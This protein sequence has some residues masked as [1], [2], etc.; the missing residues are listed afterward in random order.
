MATSPGSTA[1]LGRGSGNIANLRGDEMTTDID[2]ER[3]EAFFKEDFM[4]VHTRT[5]MPEPEDRTATATEYAA[6]HIGQMGKKID[7][8]NEKMD[9]LIAAIEA[10][11]ASRR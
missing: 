5:S 1:L 11:A 3:R 10:L 6:H 2:R 8:L 9:R 7:Q 4:P